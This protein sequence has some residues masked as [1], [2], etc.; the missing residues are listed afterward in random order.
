V[1]LVSELVTDVRAL[2]SL[3]AQWDELAIICRR[4]YCAP[5]WMLAWWH[6]AAPPTALLRVVAA[7]E[8]DSLV[9]VAPLWL[10]PGRLGRARYRVLGAGTAARLEP[11]ARPG[12]EAAAA[13][14][15]VTVLAGSSPRAGSLTFEDLPT[16][17]PWPELLARAWGASAGRGINHGDR[18]AAP[19]ATLR[20]ESLEEW[21]ASKS[22]NFRQQV[23]RARRQLDAAG[24]RF[25]V[26]T[27]P[28]LSRDLR[29]L[30]RLHYARWSER[31]GSTALDADVERM[32]EA[33]GKELLPS[34]RFRLW[35]LDRDD[36]TISVQAFVG[37][38]RELSYWLGGFDDRHAAQRPGLLT[39]VVALG[40]A[41]A[42]GEDR[43]DL[44]P[45]GQ[46]Y[47]YRLA[48]CEEQLERV[49]LILPGAS[50][51]LVRTR[52]RASRAARTVFRRLPERV[53]R[54]LRR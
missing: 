3:R 52:L 30:A 40:D 8:G 38:G 28:E 16:S 10:E 9:A 26:S 5:A 46:D 45:G 33:A 24:A 32:L 19:A 49:D 35:C 27:E 11:L 36:E 15:F 43:L 50:A 18:V 21:L 12:L 54:L 41:L 34:G 29:S 6:H 39:L 53:R 4:P 17:S 23:R 2:D 51:P 13:A 22:G 42:R 20:G 25:R 44:G 7:F 14:A 37:A 47:K 48:D 1:T 31:G